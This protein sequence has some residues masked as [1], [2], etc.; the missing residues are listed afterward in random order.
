MN[1]VLFADGW[2]KDGRDGARRSLESFWTEIGKQMPWGLMEQQKK[3]QQEDHLQQV[4]KNMCHHS[5]YHCQQQP[6]HKAQ[7]RT[8]QQRQPCRSGKKG[9]PTQ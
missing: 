1:A 3:Q 5:P 7:Q 8:P 6:Q 4:E 9:L 2:R